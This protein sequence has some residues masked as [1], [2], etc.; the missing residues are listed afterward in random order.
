MSPLGPLHYR[1]PAGAFDNDARASGFSEDTARRVDEEIRTLV[2]RG[3]ETARQ[4]IE[5]QRAAVKSLA[6]E[7]L[8]EESVDADRLRA[9]L[10]ASVVPLTTF[11]PAVR[12]AVSEA[13]LQA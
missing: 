12:D 9:L 6:E 1:R 5:R 11:P 8:Q 3:Y 7:L 4:V 13:R 2:M 10:A